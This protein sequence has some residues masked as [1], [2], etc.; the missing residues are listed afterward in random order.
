[1]RRI[2]WL[3]GLRG[4]AAIQVVL[5]IGLAQGHAGRTTIN[6]TAD[7]RAMGLTKVG[8]CE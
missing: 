4:V 5:D 1:M 7:G 3:D 2:G 8:D 6:H